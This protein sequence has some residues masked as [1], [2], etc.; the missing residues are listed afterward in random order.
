M[1]GSRNPFLQLN[2]SSHSI[3]IYNILY[4]AIM[5]PISLIMQLFILTYI[6]HYLFNLEHELIFN[7]A[8]CV[9]YMQ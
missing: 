7:T 5:N 3:K 2:Y 6:V 8:N 4:C 9:L 1:K